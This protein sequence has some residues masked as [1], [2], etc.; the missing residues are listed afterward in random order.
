MDRRLPSHGHH[1]Q[2]RVS[3]IWSPTPT[4]NT[5]HQQAPN[6]SRRRSPSHSTYCRVV[7]AASPHRTP[8][9]PRRII[10]RPRPP[11]CRLVVAAVV[12]TL[13]MLASGCWCLAA[14]DEPGRMPRMQ[15]PAWMMQ[16]S[17]KYNEAQLL[18]QQ[19]QQ[20]P[21]QPQQQQQQQ[22]PHQVQAGEHSR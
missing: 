12:A 17:A 16:S 11:E 5:Q 15:R 2:C 18:Q 8:R 7:V 3:P 6:N 21:E 14:P 19:Q 22:A 13:G 1:R 10:G 4:P 20:Q 9:P